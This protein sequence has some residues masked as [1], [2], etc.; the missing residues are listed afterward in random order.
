MAEHPEPAASLVDSGMRKQIAKFVAAR[1]RGVPRIGW[2]M[3]VHD[4]ATQQRL[5]LG[6]PLLGTLDGLRVVA[7]GGTYYPREGSQPQAEME[8]ALHLGRS[9][10]AGASLDEAREAIAGIAPAFEFVKKVNFREYGLAG[11]L[12]DSFFHDAT[13]FGEDRPLAVLEEMLRHGLPRLLLGDAV[14]SEGQPGRVPADVATVVVAAA[15][16]LARYGAALQPGDRIIC[17]SYVEPFDIAPGDK[18]TAD[19]GP[20]GRISVTVGS[21]R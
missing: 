6:G 12:E 19:L 20:L 18:L 8:V 1:Q 15:E 3:G 16:I 7:E 2:K 4:A 21:P 11:S 5:G 13:M 10:A 14:A 17:G 9:V